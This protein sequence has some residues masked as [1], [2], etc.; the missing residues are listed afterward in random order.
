M[1]VPPD[2]NDQEQLQNDSVESGAKESLEQEQNAERKADQASGF[3][4]IFDTPVQDAVE[5]SIGS[6][7]PS[8]TSLIPCS[9]CTTMLEPWQLSCHFCGKV[10]AEVDLPD[11]T[12]VLQEP[13]VLESAYQDWLR[14]G[15]ESLGKEM[16]GDAQACFVEALS[17]SKALPDATK[18]E[19]ILRKEL[20]KA[21]EKQEKRREASE[22]YALLSQLNA[23][24]SERDSQDFGQRAKQLS[25]STMDA[26]ATAGKP[27]FKT[28]TAK[29]ARVVPLYCAN[30]KRLLLEAEVYGFRNGKLLK[31]RCFC[32]Y[33]GVPL[34]R[35]DERYIRALT[36]VPVVRKRKVELIRAASRLFP[37]G[38][39][40]ETAI[41]LAALLGTFGAHKFY[42]GERF[43]G[44][45]YLALCVTGLPTLLGWYD[46]IHYSQMSRVTF[47]MQF[48]IEAVLK[49]LPDESEEPAVQNHSDLFSM[50]IT[51][52]DPEDLVDEFST[53]D[54]RA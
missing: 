15:T 4:P 10:M 17:R 48:N 2:E 16:Y 14:K 40:K 18:R 52:D 37:E 3:N 5:A 34:A 42:L 46:A 7:A 27:A 32:G 39:R 1:T 41:W 23:T 19:I 43:Q 9:A 44:Y 51:D 20:A 47:N 30:C 12:L 13:D 8:G 53:S 29:E 50:Q 54:D 26:I 31:V 11:F 35:T 28:P 36:Q 45:V 49:C 24:T 25:K 6:R 33:S 22:Q 21:L 38:K